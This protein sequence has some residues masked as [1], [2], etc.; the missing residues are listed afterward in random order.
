MKK[1]RIYSIIF[2]AVVVLV[3][4][5]VLSVAFPRTVSITHNS[6]SETPVGE[7]YGEKK[8]GQTFE[9]EHNHLS[10]IE[11][12]LATYERKNKG[13][14]FFHLRSD[15][16]S[17]EDVFK[18]K[19]KMP[20]V[21]NNRF[22]RFDFPEISSSK[23]KK[24]YF[25]MQAPKASPGNAIT[26]WSSSK[27][28]YKGGEKIVDGTAAPGDLVF[29]TEYELGWR[30]S[31]AA[32]IRR[33]GM[34]LTFFGG[35]FQNK[36][37]YFVLLLF[38][39]LWGFVTLIQKAK[40]F[41]K[42]GG[43][44]AVFSI[45]LFLITGWIILLFSKKIVVFNQFQNT[46]SVGEIQG[47]MKVGQTF[48]ASYNNLMAVEL[49]MANYERELTG[50]I[51]FHLKKRVSASDDQVVKKVDAARIKN[52]RYFRYEFPQIPNSAEKTYYFY[53]E[54]PEAQPGN[55][56]TIWGTEKDKYFEGEKIINGES[57][58]GDLTFKTVY[59]VGLPQKASLFLGEITR[60][61][62]F[63]LS[64]SW[65]YWT[66]VGLFLVSCSLFLTYL[67][68]VFVVKE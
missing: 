35:L 62:P 68:K 8:V 57:A 4:F 40:L 46:T 23:G 11:V 59:D 66:L 67:L 5:L 9:A 17:E 22:F 7:I 50:E 16:G 12:L 52:N 30:L 33:L 54:A 20:K 18:Y 27:D 10:G 48:A 64:E 29:K 51:I 6:Q 56:A 21:K 37:F 49:L 47:E 63:P 24:Y 43:F 55:A 45:L 15:V 34:I 14:F 61:K 39:F 28:L 1:R 32:L 31:G 36:V 2:V 44:F 3:G 25:F 19:G 58:K 13:A 26:I 42:K 53:L 60:A 41:Q 65:F 38:G